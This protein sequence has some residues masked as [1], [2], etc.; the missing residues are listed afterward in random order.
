[1][2][3]KQMIK[4]QLCKKCNV[5]MEEFK[6]NITISKGMFSSKH[7]YAQACEYC[8]HVEFFMQ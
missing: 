6:T 7:A 3:N 4:S 2:S 8:G 5:E 1:M